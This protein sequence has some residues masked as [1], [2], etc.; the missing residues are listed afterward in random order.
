MAQIPQPSEQPG[1]IIEVEGHTSVVLVIL[2]TIVST[3]EYWGRAMKLDWVARLR[4]LQRSAA[5]E[6]WVHK[7]E[8]IPRIF[9]SE[10]QLLQEVEQL[11]AWVLL[12]VGSVPN[13][14]DSECS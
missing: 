12:H 14:T 6:A 1:A 10:D 8:F 11:D 2:P 5:R 7:G 4:E 3:N 9:I 13:Q